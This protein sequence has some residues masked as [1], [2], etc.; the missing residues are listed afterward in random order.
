[1]TPILIRTD[2]ETA[3]ERACRE[4]AWNC[5]WRRLLDGDADDRDQKPS[6]QVD[7]ADAA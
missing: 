4:A 1:M 3:V 6:D 5:L 7:A 2:P